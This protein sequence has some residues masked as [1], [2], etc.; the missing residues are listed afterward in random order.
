MFI[1]QE[2]TRVVGIN[3]RSFAITQDMKTNR[4][5]IIYKSKQFQKIMDDFIKFNC[6]LVFFEIDKKIYELFELCKNKLTD[7]EIEVIGY[8]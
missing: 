6:D 8:F 3:G 4:K 2:I 7:V 5:N 1:N